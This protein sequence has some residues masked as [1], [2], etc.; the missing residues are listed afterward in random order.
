MKPTERRIIASV[1]VSADVIVTENRNPPGYRA[2]ESGAE[3]DGMID[4]DLAVTQWAKKERRTI[5]SALDGP[6]AR[7]AS[8]AAAKRRKR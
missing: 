4:R 5:N 1:R 7:F 3:A 2:K 6:W 8:D